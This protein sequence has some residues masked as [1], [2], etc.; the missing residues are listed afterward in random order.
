MAPESSLPTYQRITSEA[1]HLLL[2]VLVLLTTLSGWLFASARGWRINWFFGVPMPMLT[3]ENSALRDAI[4]GWHQI[5]EWA[6]LVLIAVHV[7]A[8]FVHLFYY[9]DGV[10]QRMLPSWFAVRR[11]K[12][13]PSHSRVA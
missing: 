11:A 6:L 10:I 12:G 13:K 4:D 7:S 2:Y 5:F 9:H 8:A 1:V 3:A